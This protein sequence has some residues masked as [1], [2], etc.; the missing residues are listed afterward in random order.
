MRAFF[1]LLFARIRGFLRRD[2]LE[3]DFDRE[4]AAH[5]DMAEADGLRRGLSPDEA[6]RAARVQ[7]GGLTQLRESSRAAWGL[8]WL[9]GFAADLKLGGRM[10]LKYPGLTIV[11]GLGM[12][13]AIWIG[14]I[15][16]QVMTLIINPTLPLPKAAR[17][18]EIRTMD[19]AIVD[20][21]PRVL[22]DFLD[23]RQSLQSLAELGAWT[24]SSRNLIVAKG[25]VRP[26]TVAEISASAFRV[27]D[28]QPFMGRALVDADEHPAAPLVV[29][30][31]HDLWR[32]RFDSDPQII[33]RTV[34]LGADHVTIVG[35]M[36]EGFEFPISHNLW[37]P[38]KTAGLSP[39]PRS[40]PPL[41]VFA[42]LAPGQTI[43]SA[44]AE[45][46]TL[47]QRAASD[48][49][50]THQ[51]LE[52]R[53]RPY[54]KMF[55]PDGPGE[56]AIMY[57]V[58]FFIA[59]LLVLICGNVGLLL[60]ARAASREADLVVR[61]AL[62]ASRG[63]IAAQ[64]F[65]EALALGGVAAIIG[66]SAADL[67]LRTWG[68]TLLETNYGNLPFWIDLRLSSGAFVA[69]VVLT[70]AAAAVAGIMPALKITRGMSTRLKQNTA[71]SGGLQFGGV[72]TV[73]IVAQV[74]ATVIFPAIVYFEQAQLRSTQA[75]DPG[76]AIDRYLTVQV[77]RDFPVD[78]A[79][80]ATPDR[81]ARLAATLDELRSR[82]AAQPGVAG[83]TFAE[84]LPTTNHL[85][86]TAEMGYDVVSGVTDG[87]TPE[88]RA[89]V[90]AVAP[91][92][93]AAL[94]VPILAGRGF[95]TADALP[96]AR[97][98]I[99]DQRFVDQVLQGR[100]AIG[101]QVR[102][103][104]PGPADRSWAPGNRDDGSGAGD[105]YE[106]IGVVRELGVAQPGE[107][108]GFYIPATPALFDQI[109]MLVHARGG[110]PIT[111]APQVREVAAAV[112]PAMRLVKLQRGNE[113]H[114]DALWILTM[115]MRVTVVV[116][117]V[118]VLL[119]LA[120]IYAVLAFTVARR[121]REIGVR[122]A[123]GASRRRVI[124]A[125][126]RRPLIHVT[127]GIAAGTAIVFA[128]A[129]LFKYTEFSGAN[130]ELTP[131]GMAAIV[132]YGIVMLGVC[133]LACLVPTR[134]ALKIEPTIALRSE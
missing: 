108:G 36:R 127:S 13:F 16:V 37:L 32:T 19:Q 97:V 76:F 3:S 14:L 132:G 109:H 101:Q 121:T 119:S 40:G 24:D 26:V 124:L 64:M 96:G 88:R 65:A 130:A 43:Q 75:F 73:V 53:V 104:Y 123:L 86:K 41:T 93:F 85:K 133:M 94:D 131:M 71:G 15:S 63:R 39:A 74:A 118:A 82:V 20:S 70:V 25:D 45:L 84:R 8:P 31:G 114:A 58:A 78:D 55:V 12:A 122:V 66:V 103:R 110:D 120:G 59:V 72:W 102:F 6:R 49:P 129:A 50:D 11:G 54:A 100:N 68:T 56:A 42:L 9:E 48:L 61:T 126:F 99:V 44:Q 105:W 117:S 60:F 30:I 92:Y 47:G 17:L 18:V 7:L 1:H 115:W 113:I 21:E 57:S 125:T 111:L 106:V 134:R 23:W 27:A 116:S 67:A 62:G 81:S 128:G 77:E 89:T 80:A 112:D 98:A 4:M 34:Q 90:A 22:H 38:L 79:G 91:S 29:V 33:G 95:T 10:L 69:A 87:T 51:H 52:P 83:V 46:T 2:H 28:G 107:P 35:V 5:L